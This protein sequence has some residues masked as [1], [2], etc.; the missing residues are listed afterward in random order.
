MPLVKVK[1][2]FQVTIPASLRKAIKLDIG[3]LLEAEVREDGILLTRKTVT[4]SKDLLQRFRKLLSEAMPEDSSFA[5]KS[6]SE[7]MDIAIEAVKET[8]AEKNPKNK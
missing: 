1:D 2:K 4:D 6:E 5:N 3:D 7:L 8:R